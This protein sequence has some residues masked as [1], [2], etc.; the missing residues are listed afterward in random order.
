MKKYFGIDID[1]TMEN[2]AYKYLDNISADT[3]LPEWMKTSLLIMKDVYNTWDQDL[4]NVLPSGKIGGVNFGAIKKTNDQEDSIMEK[5]IR[6]QYT[7]DALNQ[8]YDPTNT[9][10]KDVFKKQGF[11]DETATFLEKEATRILF[12]QRDQRNPT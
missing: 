2:E 1:S 5:K 6:S 10:F 3:T 12:D 4:L 9:S 11:P 8:L 7:L